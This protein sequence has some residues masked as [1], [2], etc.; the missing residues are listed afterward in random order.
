[1]RQIELNLEG[2]EA[3]IELALE[4]GEAEIELALEGGEAETGEGMVN[5][6]KARYF[7]NKKPGLLS[8]YEP[9]V[10]PGTHINGTHFFSMIDSCLFCGGAF[11]HGK[12]V[13]RCKRDQQTGWRWEGGGIINE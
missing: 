2:G 6:F 12:G 7:P 5:I 4:G 8:R 1:M 13:E 10:F 11:V 9:H 3:E